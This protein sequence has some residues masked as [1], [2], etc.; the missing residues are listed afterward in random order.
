MEGISKITRA[1]NRYVLAS[2]SD[3]MIVGSVADMQLKTTALPVVTDLGD[4]L[5][6]PRP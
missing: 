2:N 4:C 6:V 5:L 1:A 3:L